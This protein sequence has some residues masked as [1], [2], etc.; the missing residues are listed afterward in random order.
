MRRFWILV[1]LASTL[2]GGQAKPSLGDRF[3]QAVVKHDHAALKKLLADGFPVNA[4][5]DNGNLPLGWVVFMGGNDGE[6]DALLG[7]G[8]KLDL[9]DQWG[10]TPLWRRPDGT[11]RNAFGISSRSGPALWKPMPTA[12]PQ[13][14]TR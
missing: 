9:H 2:A 1:C 13:C 7:D 4:R 11:C 8:A 14:T 12:G 3:Y 10:R 5:L 6:I